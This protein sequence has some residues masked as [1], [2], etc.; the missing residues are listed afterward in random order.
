MRRAFLAASATMSLAIAA[1]GGLALARQTPAAEP[2]PPRAPGYLT[3]ETTPDAALVMP[4]PPTPGTDRYA[5]DRAIFKATRALEGSPRWK[6]AQSDNALTTADLE[7]DFSCAVGA[8]ITPENSPKL[9]RLLA[10]AITD[11]GKV[12]N[13]AKDSLHRLRPYK[14]DDGNI[15]IPHTARLDGTYDYPS[16]H[17]TI[18]W[19]WGSILAELAPDRSTQALTRARAFGESRVV[20]GVHNASAIEAGRLAG[21]MTVAALDGSA[22]FRGDLEAARAEL[23]AVRANPANAVDAG[24]CQAE[25]ELIAKTPYPY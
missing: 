7:R 8:R 4:P 11:A 2:T 14:I 23:A 18:S 25:A 10:R 6:L 22:E 24:Q 12:Y 13:P 21:A 19:V 15:C 3:A 20:C 1:A 17:T 9:T 16:G 5:A